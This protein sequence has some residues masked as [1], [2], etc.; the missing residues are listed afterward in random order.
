MRVKLFVKLSIFAV[1]MSVV[2]SLSAHSQNVKITPLNGHDGEFCS[3]DRAML[4]EDPDCMRRL[5][6]NWKEVGI[7]N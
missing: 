4:F 6:Q 1:V 5:L 3:R 2:F 7:T